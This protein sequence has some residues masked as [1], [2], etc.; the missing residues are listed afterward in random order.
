MRLRRSLPARW[1]RTTRSC[2]NCTLNRPL[3]NFSNTVPVTSMLSSLLIAL[4]RGVTPFRGVACGPASIGK[5]VRIHRSGGG[6]VGRLQTFRPFRYFKF[7]AGAFI[8]TAISLRLN[9][10]EM[11]ED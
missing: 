8:Q 9:R 5:P 3:G 2:S 11:Y 7:H 6:D 10:R 1:A 4:H